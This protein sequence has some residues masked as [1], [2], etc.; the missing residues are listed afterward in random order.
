MARA[1]SAW[2]GPAR[3]G[4]AGMAY[5]GVACSGES[6][7]GRH[8]TAGLGPAAARLVAALCGKSGLGEA[9]QAG[10]ALV[11]PGGARYAIARH[12]LAGSARQGS[13]CM[14]GQAGQGIS[15]RGDRGS[16]REGLARQARHGLPGRGSAR[17]RMTR[18]GGHGPAFPAR[19]GAARQACHG[20]A[21]VGMVR[22]DPAL[23]GTARCGM[24]GLARRRRGLV[25]HGTARLGKAGLARP[26]WV[27][28]RSAWH[29]TAAHGWLARLGGDGTAASAWTGMDGLSWRGKARPGRRGC[30]VGMARHGSARQARHGA[31]GCGSA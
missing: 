15:R 8:G 30:G 7:C 2:F 29:I 6:R 21:G 1:S 11:R 24:A 25:P 9:G 4:V 13:R 19:L 31:V 26:G 3:P 10:L 23:L 17:H 18:H 5:V 16:V 12:G 14:A 20:S 28:F 22:S 27:R